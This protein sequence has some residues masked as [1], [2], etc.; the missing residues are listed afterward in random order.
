M[1]TSAL[2]DAILAMDFSGDWSLVLLTA[3]GF[4]C[5]NRVPVQLAVIGGAL[6]CEPTTIKLWVE[7]SV[8]DEFS[9]PTQLA[10]ADPDRSVKITTP[11]R[12]LGLAGRLDLGDLVT[13]MCAYDGSILAMT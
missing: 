6:I 11:L 1:T 8:A 12:Q 4:I 9:P 3:A 7:G 13:I 5:S 10:I 2:D